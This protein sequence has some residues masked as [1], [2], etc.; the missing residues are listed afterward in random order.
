ME[1]YYEEIRDH[2]PVDLD[3]VDGGGKQYDGERILF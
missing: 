3:G 2:E 1:K